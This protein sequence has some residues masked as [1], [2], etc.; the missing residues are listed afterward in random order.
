MLSNMTRVD[1]RELQHHLGRYLD[2]VEAGEIL[3]VRRRRRVIARVVP[4]SPEEPSEA[5]P[6]LMERLTRLYPEGPIAE[7]AA[8]RLYR[9]RDR[10]GIDSNASN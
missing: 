8:E 9:D 1:V 4:F 5:W 2:A 6:D 7:S 10:D 3:E